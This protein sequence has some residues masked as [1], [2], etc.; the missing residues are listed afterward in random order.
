LVAKREAQI[1]NIA[2]LGVREFFS[3][4]VAHIDRRLLSSVNDIIEINFLD[5]FF[6]H[7]TEDD[8]LLFKS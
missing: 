2:L 5:W 4:I 1:I 7:I 3:A 6:S 8:I